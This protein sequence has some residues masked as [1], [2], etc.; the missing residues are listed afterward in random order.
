MPTCLYCETEFESKPM[1]R[2]QKYCSLSCGN[3]MR[4]CKS[5]ELYN[6]APTL[7]KSCA[8][9]LSF[10]QH[11]QGKFCNKSCSATY[12]NK[13]RG[14]EYNAMHSIRMKQYNLLHPKIRKPKKTLQLSCRVCGVSFNYHRIRQT[15]SRACY[16]FTCQ[17]SGRKAAATRCL[18]SKAEIALYQLCVVVFPDS[19]HNE[20]IADGWDA[21][22]VIPSLQ[23]AI[24]WNGPWHYQNM[25]VTNHSLLQVQTRD[26]IKKE[27]FQQLGWTVL[28]FE[29][30]FYTPQTAFEQVKLVAE[31]LE[32]NQL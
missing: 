32:S 27:L 18:R 20:I 7:C 11:K 3:L 28:V 19:M 2:G 17:V 8:K 1:Q 31:G 24:L 25:P 10:E 23:L 4:G 9:P 30:R 6:L 5:K 15:C 21:D 29:D 26:R 22:I 13:F 14:P 12:N 16:N